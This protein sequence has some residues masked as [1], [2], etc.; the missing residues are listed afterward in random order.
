MEATLRWGEDLRDNWNRKL[1]NRMQKPT[2]KP[3]VLTDRIFQCIEIERCI[4]DEANA[5]ILGA[6]SAESGHSCNDGGSALLEVVADNTLFDDVGND[7]DGDKDKEDEE[8]VAVNA[9]DDE[10]VTAVT[11][12]C[13]RPQSLP[14]FVGP[15]IGVSTVESPGALIVPGVGASS[16]VASSASRGEGD[17]KYAA[18]P[19]GRNSS[20]IL[21]RMS[22]Q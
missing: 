8:V 20:T 14:A 21:M 2:G 7:D 5:T 22:F 6:D 11:M 15:G 10:N 16:A 12:V 1:C 4:Q 17:S 9:P 18:R 19:W 13:P 3:G